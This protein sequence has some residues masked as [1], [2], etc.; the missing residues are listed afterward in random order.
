MNLE[1]GRNDPVNYGA[2]R[3]ALADELDPTEIERA[4]AGD[5]AAQER[6]YRCYERRVYTLAYRLMG[7]VA[8]A[9]DVTQDC[10][11]RCFEAMHQFR[12]EA[13]FWAWLKQLTVRTAL[14]RLRSKR[15][16]RWLSLDQD[17]ESQAMLSDAALAQP[18]PEN[19]MGAS[20]D[21]QQ[22]LQQLSSTARAVVY[23]YYGEGY[24][25][26]EIAAMWG[27][28]VSFSKSQLARA[29]QRLRQ[30]LQPIED[31]G[32][33]SVERART[34]TATGPQVGRQMTS[35]ALLNEVLP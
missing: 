1:S 18:G 20:H 23:L 29:Q 5:E 12:G 22:A 27:K 4:A 19:Q 13:P 6:L 33:A 17:D 28:S 24:S 9:Q 10:F 25:H 30:C 14:M 16:W 21:L 35:I 26:A 3:M 2:G 34:A 7:Q 31:S 8:D 15:R 11:I 32:D